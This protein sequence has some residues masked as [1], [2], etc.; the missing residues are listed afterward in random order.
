LLCL[1]N[2]SQSVTIDAMSE[3]DLQPDVDVHSSPSSAE[4]LCVP[5]FGILHLLIWTAIT[6]A[7]L[8]LLMALTSQ[9]SSPLP[10]GQTWFL[11]LLG[12]MY[13]IV[14]AAMLVGAG[15]LIRARCYTLFNRLQP[16]HW[17]VLLA[18]L[19]FI[20]EVMTALLLWLAS[21]AATRALI[22]FGAYMAVVNVLTAAAYGYAFFKLHDARRWKLVIGM[23]GI[24]IGATAAVTVLSLLA[25][26]L[27]ASSP[28]YLMGSGMMQAVITYCPVLWS[29]AVFAI[30]LIAASVDLYRRTA[31]D[32]VHWLGVVVLGLTYVHA[33][34]MQ[35]YLMFFF[36]LP[37]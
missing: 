27:H 19:E 26:L 15:A 1:S 10:S 22:L 29:V 31:R 5:Q 35:V 16:G 23:K 33:L 20:V 32:W 34:A 11:L 21:V 8:K 12:S 4:Q 13:A 37:H 3:T 9:F 2:C 30:L 18:T 7:F 25:N 17:L 36:R 24:G 6:A 28:L 14:L